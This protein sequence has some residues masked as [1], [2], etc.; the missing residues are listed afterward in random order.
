[1]ISGTAF[2]LLLV[3]AA[4]LVEGLA[5]IFMK[6]AASA[7]AASPLFHQVGRLAA[8]AWLWL[9]L[10]CFAAEMCLWTIA[11]HHLKVSV[12]F[13]L[14]SLCFV[15]VAAL[16]RVFLHERIGRTR[17]LG[18]LLILTGCMFIGFAA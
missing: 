5:Q 11:L 13:P 10:A 9:A 4:A 18:I 8:N 14:G 3:L 2:G 7:P 16:S 1:M 15:V 12:A 17:W 6:Y